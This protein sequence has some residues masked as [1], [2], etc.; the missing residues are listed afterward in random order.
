MPRAHHSQCDSHAA[1][2]VATTPPPAWG[3]A[4]PPLAIDQREGRF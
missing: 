4:A 2:A 1:A 3:L